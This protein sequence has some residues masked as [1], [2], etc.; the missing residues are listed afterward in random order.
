M[1]PDELPIACTLQPADLADRLAAWDGL[2]ERA[3]RERR[4]IPAGMRLVFAAGD[5]VEDAV[6][7][8][9]RLEAGCCAFADWTVHRHGEDVVL[10]VTAAGEGVAAV[11]ALFEA[12]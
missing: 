6:A 9:A 1:P 11:R 5:G 2:S 7:E 10:D 4:T 3:L 8:L 12:G